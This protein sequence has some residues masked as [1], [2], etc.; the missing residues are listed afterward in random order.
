MKNIFLAFSVSNLFVMGH[1]Y[2]R[3]NH[4]KSRERREERK[5]AVAG[6]TL[7]SVQ[8]NVA[9]KRNVKWWSIVTQHKFTTQKHAT[10]QSCLVFFAHVDFFHEKKMSA[11]DF[12]LRT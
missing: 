12:A 11:H 5:P 2:A 9:S 1:H 8:V 4:K 7:T 3:I 6:E 10:R